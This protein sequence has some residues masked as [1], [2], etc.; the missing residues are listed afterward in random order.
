MGNIGREDVQKVLGYLKTKVNEVCYIRKDSRLRTR[1]LCPALRSVKNSVILRTN[2]FV[3]AV[4]AD[5]KDDKAK[6]SR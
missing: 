4:V 1:R 5:Q 3:P 2:T 6:T